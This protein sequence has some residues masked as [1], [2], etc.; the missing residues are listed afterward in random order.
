M[1]Q[2]LLAVE[3]AAARP[4]AHLLRAR[5]RTHVFHGTEDAVAAVLTAEDFLFAVVLEPLEPVTEL[6]MLIEP[7]E[8]AGNRALDE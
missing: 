1:V 7:G 6:R 5:L 8:D 2:R 4:V 3:S